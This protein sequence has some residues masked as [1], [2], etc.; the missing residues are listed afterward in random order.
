MDGGRDG[1]VNGAVVWL[2]AALAVEAAAVAAYW[3]LR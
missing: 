3:F 2:L 1:K